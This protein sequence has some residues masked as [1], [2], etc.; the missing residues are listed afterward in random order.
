MTGTMRSCEPPCGESEGKTGFQRRSSGGRLV[1]GMLLCNGVG[2]RF[3]GL[4]KP[5]AVTMMKI[6]AHGSDAPG[7]AGVAVGEVVS[8]GA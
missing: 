1:V 4:T 8:H 5:V 3:R 7:V 6:A 2:C